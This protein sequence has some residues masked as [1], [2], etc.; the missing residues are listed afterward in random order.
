MRRREFITVIASAAATWPLAAH[1]EPV[2]GAVVGFLSGR[3]LS[4]DA[5]LVKAFKR[6][7]KET[8]YIEGQNLKI[9]FRWAE[10]Q[11]DR[12]PAM[13]ADLIGGGAAVIFAGGMDVQVRA[14]KSALSGVRAVYAVG[15]DPVEYALSRA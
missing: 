14:V 7:L 8:G 6:G 15:G 11:F 9:E 4:T 10:G 3:S 12:L 1:A 13:A 2:T 5:D